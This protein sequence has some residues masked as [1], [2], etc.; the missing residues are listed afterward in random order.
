MNSIEKGSAL[1]FLSLPAQSVQEQVGIFKLRRPK[2]S[3]PVGI[4]K[5][6]NTKVKRALA[7]KTKRNKPKLA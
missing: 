6:K 2:K 1:T 5:F 3:N 4:Y 7:F